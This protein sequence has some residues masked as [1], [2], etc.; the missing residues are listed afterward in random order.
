MDFAKAGDKGYSAWQELGDNFAAWWML[1][2]WLFSVVY[3]FFNMYTVIG[4]ELQ[5]LT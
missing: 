2:I 5:A 4:S 1:G 3:F